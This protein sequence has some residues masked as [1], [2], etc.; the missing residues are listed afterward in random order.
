M[1]TKV[2]KWMTRV[3]LHDQLLEEAR[4]ISLFE[5]RFGYPPPPVASESSDL[6]SVLKNALDEGRAPEGWTPTYDGSWTV[7]RTCDESVAG[8]RD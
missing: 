5:G 7:F 1:K 8:E 2:D 3:T 6:T 4:L